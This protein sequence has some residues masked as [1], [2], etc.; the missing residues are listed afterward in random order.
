METIWLVLADVIA[1]TEGSSGSKIGFMNIT[2]W[3]D[4]NAI[5]LE[6]FHTYKKN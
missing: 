4:S 3:D 6:A 5:V 1:D 2:T